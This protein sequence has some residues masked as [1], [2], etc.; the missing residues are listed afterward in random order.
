MPRF[1]PE[2]SLLDNIYIPFYSAPEKQ[3]KNCA[4]YFTY[5]EPDTNGVTSIIN[6]M[7]DTSDEIAKPVVPF[8]DLRNFDSETKEWY[9]LDASGYPYRLFSDSSSDTGW[10]LRA[11]WPINYIDKELMIDTSI[12]GYTEQGKSLGFYSTA[13]LDG[14]EINMYPS[15]PVMITIAGKT[16]VDKTIYGTRDMTMG[17]SALNSDVNPEFYYDYVS[18]KIYTNQNLLAYDPNHIKV[19]FF[20]SLN[21]VSIKARL[22]SN[23]GSD[24]FY[25]PVVDYYIAKLNGQFLLRG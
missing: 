14:N 25:T 11:L 16:L 4:D 10:I 19:Y 22:A 7:T 24:A 13:I 17:I 23:S 9:Y 8:I 12:V 3:V 20:K 6:L 15:N 1:I 2:S 5:L 18:N 21:E